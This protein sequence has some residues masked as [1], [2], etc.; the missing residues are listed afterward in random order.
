[1]VSG[2]TLCIVIEGFVMY[3][4]STITGVSWQ[5]GAYNYPKC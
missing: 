4:K 5:L 2:K 3:C 1:M